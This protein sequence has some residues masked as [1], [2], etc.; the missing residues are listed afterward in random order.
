MKSINDIETPAVLVDLDV[1]EKNLKHTADL[2]KQAGVRLRPHCKTHKSVWLAKKQ[3]EYGACGIT[4]AKLSEA[5]V[6]IDGG[7]TDILVAYPIIGEAKLARL[8][9]LLDRASLI[10]SADSVAGAKGLSDL[11]VKLNQKIRIYVD[12]NSGLQRCG[13]EPGEETAELVKSI[14]DF[15]GIEIVG[16]MTHG[17]FSYDYNDRESLLLAARR[18]AD[19]LLVTQEMLRKDGI[20]IQEISV[21]STPTSKFIGEMPEGITEIR[22]GAYVYGDDQQLSIGIITEEECAMHILTTVVSAPRI[23]SVIVDAGLK[24]LCSDGCPYREGYGMNRD[25]HSIYIAELCEEHGIVKMPPE[26]KLNVGDRI[27][28]LPNHCCATTNMHD[29]LYGVRNGVVE[30]MIKVDARGKVL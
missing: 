30:R 24:T 22:P 21:G 1:L 19:A 16:L 17:G 6:M 10:V 23:G 29:E 28:I 12:V 8:E 2:A 15:P 11:G 26:K 25:D 4:V 14:I 27:Q 20:D 9:K 5:E 3:L 13:M 7:I 18:E